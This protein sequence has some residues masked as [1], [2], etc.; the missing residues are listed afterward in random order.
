MSK[1]SR[2]QLPEHYINFIAHAK[3]VYENQRS[4]HLRGLPLS[5]IGPYTVNCR[6][7]AP[8]LSS[9]MSSEAART[10]YVKLFSSFFQN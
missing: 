10:G 2:K 4:D 9:I 7:L 8:S 5:K 6:P 1:L 3:R